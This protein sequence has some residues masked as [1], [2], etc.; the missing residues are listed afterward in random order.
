MKVVNLKTVTS[1]N[2]VRNAEVVGTLN[3]IDVVTVGD[4]VVCTMHDARHNGNP[5]GRRMVLTGTRAEVES[6]C[7]TLLDA[8]A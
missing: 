5:E 1:R 4:S 6:F 2:A 7:K 3:A 8:M